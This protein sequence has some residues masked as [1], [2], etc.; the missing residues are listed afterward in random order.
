MLGYARSAFSDW[1]PA[2]AQTLQRA[3]RKLENEPCAAW[4]C[5]HCSDGAHL[6][7]LG[8]PAMVTCRSGCG[9]L[10]AGCCHSLVS[11]NTSYRLGNFL[12][13]EEAQAV[14]LSTDCRILSRAS[15]EMIM[16]VRNFLCWNSRLDVGSMCVPNT[17]KH[18]YWESVTDVARASSYAF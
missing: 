9:S 12:A 18:V 6:R 11:G 5:R 8:K 4:V 3:S 15:N 17:E 16:A 10:L 1:V 13:T 2:A 14:I 7:G